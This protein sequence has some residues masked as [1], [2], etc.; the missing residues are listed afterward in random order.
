MSHKQSKSSAFGQG[1][2]IF[3]YLAVLTAIEYAIAV[4][5]N[6]VSILV[7]VAVIKAALVM[8]YYMH[9]Y[10]LNEE[11]DSDEHSYSFKTGTNRIGLWLFLLSDA[12]VFAGLMTARINLLGL[13][14]IG[15]ASCRERV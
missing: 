7:V 2:V 6:A 11:G 10:K 9:V 4:T 1:V 13:T 5:F 14:Q 3:I 8:Y 12:F 15:R